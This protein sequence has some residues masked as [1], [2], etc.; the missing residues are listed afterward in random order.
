MSASAVR[1]VGAIGTMNVRRFSR[2]RTNVFF[3][4]VFPVVLV[5]IIGL[6]F[7]GDQ[8][9]RMG[10]V[11]EAQGLGEAL[12]DELR[13]DGGI[14]IVEVDDEDALTARVEST[15][16]DAGIVLPVDP[17]DLVGSGGRLEIGFVA[18]STDAG[19]QMA[20]VVDGALA[21]VLALPTAEQAAVDRGAERAEAHAAA[22][23]LAPDTLDRVEVRLV[24]T[25]DRIFPEGLGQWDVAAPSQLVLFTFITGLTGSAALIQTRQLGI[26]TRMMATPT[27]VRSIILGEALGRL[28]I[29][30][31]QGLYILL[32][33]MLLFGVGWGDPLGAMAVVVALGI[34]SAGA[35]MCF[36]TFFHNPEQASGLGVVTALSLAA[37]GGAMLPIEL[38]SDTL[39]SVARFTPHYWAIDGFAELIRHDG[40]LVDIGP[41]LG[42]LIAFAVALLL[43]ASWRMRVVLTRRS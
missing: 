24:T 33:T 27:S 19:Q 2:D 8:D 39:A 43:L 10:V 31:I 28:L 13:S 25:G 38:F 32:G 40:S 37:L 34:V 36:G 1:K 4:F 41:Q 12:V 5:L 14:E 26:S 17:D 7:G 30:L 11:G 18:G 21:R 35:A 15:D 42:V 23:R 16:L 29:G 3:V 20:T 9:P 6:Q 22:E